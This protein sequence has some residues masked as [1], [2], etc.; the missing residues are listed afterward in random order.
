MD[1]GEIQ[2]AR[3]FIAVIGR[4]NRGLPHLPNDVAKALVSQIVRCL[5]E[6][7]P[8]R[9]STRQPVLAMR[10]DAKG[11]ATSI[12]PSNLFID[13]PKLVKLAASSVLTIAGSVAAPWIAP[14]AALVVIGDVVDALKVKI[15]ERAAIVL[16]TLW[17]HSDGT[18]L[19]RSDELLERVNSELSKVEDHAFT[20]TELEEAWAF[21]E[22]LGCVEHVG[23][24][25]PQ[26]R[27]QER[28]IIKAD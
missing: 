18:G 26:V 8:H 21:L 2:A 25:P 13:L 23:G 4:V 3:Q 6:V 11:D 14:L 9:T 1:P 22:K 28:V 19:F 24:D 7:E 16:W 27:L 10:L 5:C 17:K 20:K 12:K 15:P